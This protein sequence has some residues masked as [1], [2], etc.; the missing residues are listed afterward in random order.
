MTAEDARLFHAPHQA[1]G[2]FWNPWN[3]Q[4]RGLGDLLRWKLGR[5]PYGRRRPPQVPV[6]ENDGAGRLCF[7]SASRL[8]RSDFGVNRRRM[9]AIRRDFE[10]GTAAG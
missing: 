2:R 3:P 10:A 6:V 5:N 4:T 7:R 9:E 1:G 8:G